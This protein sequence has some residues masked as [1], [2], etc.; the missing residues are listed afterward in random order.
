ML[1]TLPT[2]HTCPSAGTGKS[3]LVCAISIGLGGRTTLLGRA[4][5]LKDYVRRAH[6]VQ[7]GWV[8]VTL[9]SGQPGRPYTVRAGEGVGRPGCPA[10][11]ARPGA[12]QGC[13]CTTMARG[14]RPAQV[15]LAGG[16][17]PG[18]V[19]PT[20]LYRV[21]PDDRGTPPAATPNPLHPHPPHTPRRFCV[22]CAAR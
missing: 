17:A 1:R 19:Q 21:P 13:P 7:T 9:S 15:R 5:D 8:E 10:M 11:R 12:L 6:G 2:A 3:S 14:A 22:R 16:A 20:R 18:R 4:E